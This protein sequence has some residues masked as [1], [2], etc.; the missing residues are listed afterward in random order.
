M[1]SRL[2]KKTDICIPKLWSNGTARPKRRLQSEAVTEG[3][4]RRQVKDVDDGSKQG[5]TL[6]TAE[7]D[8]SNRVT[9]NRN[10]N[11]KDSK[12]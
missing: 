4:W 6:A 8:D 12:L 7:S 11:I 1:C 2:K 10:S 3:N 9:V 5:L